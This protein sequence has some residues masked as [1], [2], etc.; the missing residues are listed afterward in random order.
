MAQA[1]FHSLHIGGVDLQRQI[2]HPLQGKQR[3]LHHSRLVNLRQAYIHIQNMGA[4]IFLGNTLFDKIV[5]ILF[6][7][8]G[9][10]QLFAGGVDPLAYNYRL[11]AQL[12][13]L[14]IA[15]HQ[16]AGRR[17]VHHRRN[18]LDPLDHLCNMRRSGAAAAAQIAD[19]QLGNGLHLLC[20]GLRVHIIHR[21]AVNRLRQ[22]GVG[23]HD[24]GQASQ[25][26]Q[27][28]HQGQHLVR[29]H[30][31]VKAQGVYPQSLQ[32]SHRRF[33][34]RAGKQPPFFVHDHGG[35]YRQVTIF[36]GRQYRRLQLQ[37]VAHGL[38]KHQVRTGGTGTNGAGKQVIG[39]VKSQ[40][41]HG[42]KQLAQRANVQHNF[43]SGTAHQCGGCLHQFLYI[44]KLQAVGA[45][46]IGAD[47]LCS[48]VRIRLMNGG[49][50]LRVSQVQRLRQLTGAKQTGCLEHGAHA[51]VKKA[52][53][54]HALV[55]RPGV[56]YR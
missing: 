29:S 39:V 37:R 56:Q 38:N 26:P 35:K 34:I 7:Q 25:L 44:V 23:V 19:P 27:L 50:L 48:G 24:D 53:L 12:H 15:A 14:G 16:G 28:R 51:A 45:K 1:H 33:N 6:P 54:I 40:L 8:G 42:L 22:P 55:L 13:R 30:G 5:N 36:L 10:H 17:G 47:K 18:V 46:G 2:Q 3:L 20:K 52:N 32:H 49:D 9:F 31:A 21:L 41:A 11:F 4:L 43:L